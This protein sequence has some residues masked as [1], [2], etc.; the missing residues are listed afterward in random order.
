M[1]KNILYICGSLLLA[2]LIMTN[3]LGAK[4]ANEVP[5][6]PVAPTTVANE[7][8]PNPAPGYNQA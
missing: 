7:V 3:G 5:P 8:P 4:E 2:G 1:K 6:N